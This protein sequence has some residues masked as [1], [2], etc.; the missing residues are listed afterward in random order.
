MSKSDLN[1]MSPAERQR[2]SFCV[3]PIR[4]RRDQQARG[5]QCAVHPDG[6]D[7]PEAQRIAASLLFFDDRRQ[8]FVTWPD[9]VEAMRQGRYAGAANL[10]LTLFTWVNLMR[11]LETLHDPLGTP[12][13][14][15]TEEQA[16][17]LIAWSDAA[18]TLEER[19]GLIT[20]ARGG[21]THAI[22]T[23]FRMSALFGHRAG[24]LSMVRATDGGTT[25]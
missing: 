21:V 9:A 14:Q 16:D 19:R 5:P 6:H 8:R 24:E 7:L 25:E 2:R 11:L 13:A 4:A 17:A 12:S 10:E 18:I 23:L 20:V 3:C 1:F 15:L 22:C